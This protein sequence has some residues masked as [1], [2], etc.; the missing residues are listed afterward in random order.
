MPVNE[1]DKAYVLYNYTYLS[2][3]LYENL[4]IPGDVYPTQLAWATDTNQQYTEV[5][6]RI[7]GVRVIPTRSTVWYSNV[8]RR[9]V[10]IVSKYLGIDN[11]HRSYNFCP[12]TPIW[13]LPLLYRHYHPSERCIPQSHPESE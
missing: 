12:R 4:L 7:I 9:Q 2:Y 6:S 10:A 1:I 3:F 5:H 11:G 13:R 8:P